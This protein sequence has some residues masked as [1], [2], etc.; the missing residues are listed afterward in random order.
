ME[1][2]GIRGI[3]EGFHE[4]GSRGTHDYKVPEYIY[5]F[6]FFQFLLPRILIFS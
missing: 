5:I 2:T 4:G 6:V 3:I 1:T